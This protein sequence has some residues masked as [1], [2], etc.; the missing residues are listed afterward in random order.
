M[1]RCVDT[2]LTDVS[3]ERIASIFRVPPKRRLTQD[4]HS[5]TYQKTTFFIAIA[6]KLSNRT[7][8]I[9]ISSYSPYGRLYFCIN[10]W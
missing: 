7:T 10:N 8:Y 6:V 2:G 5:A 3:E 4:V 1:W 9:F